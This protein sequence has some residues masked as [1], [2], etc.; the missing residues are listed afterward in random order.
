MYV[1]VPR[2]AQKDPVSH[3]FEELRGTQYGPFSRCL[4]DAEGCL[5]FIM[6][7][8]SS[9][10]ATINRTIHTRKIDRGLNKPRLT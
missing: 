7:S 2:K 8:L 10:S 4:P 3:E 6:V 1:S 5:G 9:A